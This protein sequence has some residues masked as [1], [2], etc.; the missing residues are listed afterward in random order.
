MLAFPAWGTSYFLN[1]AAGGGSDSNNGLST[2]APWL[3][4]NHAVNCGDTITAAASTTYSFLNFQTFGTVTCAG[5]NN[6]A[7]LQCAT[8]DACKI[9]FSSSLRVGIEITTSYWGVQGFEVDGTTATGNC[10]YAAPPGSPATSGIHHIIFANNIANGCGLAGIG[11]ASNSTYGVDYIVIVG[12]IAY[13]N[14]SG[15]VN[16]SSGITIYEPVASDTL[17]GTHIYVA[18]N[19]SYKNLNGDP[20][21]GGTP[22]DGEGIIFDTFDGNQSGFT[23]AYSQQALAE[24]NIIL[25]NGGRG[26]VAVG[27]GYSGDSVPAPYANIVLRQNTTW[28]NNSDTNQNQSYCGE[29]LFSFVS[30]VS[31]Y[32][33]LNQA[34]SSTGCGS[35]SLYV[36]YVG[37]SNATDKLYNNWGYSAS[38][39]NVGTNLSPGFTA[40]PNN[41]FSN[42]SFTNATTPGAPS[43]GSAS[44]V[45]NCMATVVANF[46]PTTSGSTGYGYQIPGAQR[47]DPLFPAW[48]CNVNLPTGLVTMG[49]STISGGNAT[50]GPTTTAGPV[51]KQ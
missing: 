28:G 27:N 4:P 31:A 40:G 5:G 24:N 3:T 38:A 12:N 19:F 26:I 9:N 22:S 2:G 20:C 44:S 25:A 42:P 39:Q 8:F 1:T 43:C 51:T 30:N 23:V 35:N 17:P 37:G 41:T 21:G 11:T 48:L 16:C 34:T 50:A 46:T 13:G 14:A 32:G 18:G 10:F 15:S 49:C 6:V 7:W 47:A 36:Y 29:I 45:P 33:N